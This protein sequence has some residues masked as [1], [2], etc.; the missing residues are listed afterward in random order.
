[1]A[2]RAG[3]FNTDGLRFPARLSKLDKSM[4]RLDQIDAER[5]CPMR[6]LLHASLIAS[7]L[8]AHLTPPTICGPVLLRK[9]RPGQRYRCLLAAWPCSLLGPVSRAPRSSICRG[10]QRNATG[11]RL[12][13]C[14]PIREEIISGAVSLP[15]WISSATGNVN[16][17][18]ENQSA[19]A[20]I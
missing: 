3:F 8:A 10:R 18:C 4:H 1:M 13:N 5:P 14:S 19:G 15:S 16:L 9:V 7:I 12:Q 6:T 17:G 11:N 2:P 20:T